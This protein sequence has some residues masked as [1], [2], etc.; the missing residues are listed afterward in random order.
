MRLGCRFEEFLVVAQPIM[1]R[2]RTRGHSVETL[3]YRAIV[4]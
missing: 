2:R 3:A 4:D 1:V